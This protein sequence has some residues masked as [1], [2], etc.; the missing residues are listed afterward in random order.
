MRVVVKKDAQTASLTAC[1]IFEAFI[2]RN[3]AAVLGLA[4]GSTPVMLYQ[5]MIRR[6]RTGAMDFSKITTFNLDEYV[7]LSETDPNSYRVFM[8]EQLFNHLNVARESTHVP[9]GIASDLEHVCAA[10]ERKI[11]EAGGIDIQLLGIGRNGHI[12]FN[13]PGSSFSSRTRVKALTR[14]TI[15]D[16]ARFFGGV[17]RVPKSAVTMGVKTILDARHIVLI[18]VGDSKA[19]IVREFI[20]G[21]LTSMVPASILQTHSAVTVILDEAAAS[22]LSNRQ[23]YDDS[24]QLVDSLASNLKD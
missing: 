21:P 22:K 17:D 13:E 11:Q 15:Q 10:Y 9:L 18:A 14:Q 5:E 4:T 6:Y 19:D 8:N 3:P 20:E 12:G 16:N 23:Y 1:D 7:G 24:E 2:R